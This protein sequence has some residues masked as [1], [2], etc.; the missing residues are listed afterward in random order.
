MVPVFYAVRER[1]FQKL[2]TPLFNRGDGPSRRPPR[3]WSAAA[4]IVTGLVDINIFVIIARA[5]QVELEELLKDHPLKGFDL[6]L[7]TVHFQAP[8]LIPGTDSLMTVTAPRGCIASTFPSADPITHDKTTETLTLRVGFP[9]AGFSPI[10]ARRLGSPP[11][12]VHIDLL[13]PDLQGPAVGELL[14]KLKQPTGIALLFLISAAAARGVVKQFFQWVFGNSWVWK[15]AEVIR[16][17]LVSLPK[18]A[19]AFANFY[20]RQ[21][22]MFR[23][24]TIGAI[25]IVGA[26]FLLPYLLF[27][28]IIFMFEPTYWVA[29]LLI[30][31]VLCLIEIIAFVIRRLIP[32]PV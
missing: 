13:K 9:R 4:G 24:S 17:H 8:A 18:P 5:N 22:R 27:G 28:A 26:C 10:D 16:V 30:V 7:P 11:W 15:Q 3:R 12:T 19:T 6:D 29:G 20:A 31:I 32:R 14:R 2:P 25:C 1:S 21:S 23:W